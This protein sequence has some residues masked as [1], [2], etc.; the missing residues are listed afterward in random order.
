M[1][2]YGTVAEMTLLEVLRLLVSVQLEVKMILI[3]WLKKIKAITVLINYNLQQVHNDKVAIQNAS[4]VI[5]KFLIQT[6][7]TNSVCITIARSKN[8]SKLVVEQNTKKNNF[9]CVEVSI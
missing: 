4:T 9:K 1:E 6:A 2:K 5:K 3:C 7:E 8:Y